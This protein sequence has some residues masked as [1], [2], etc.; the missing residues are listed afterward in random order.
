MAQGPDPNRHP[1]TDRELS[2][3]EQRRGGGTGSPRTTRL[4]LSSWLITLLAVALLI[5]FLALMR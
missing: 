1:G 2:G 3:R 4:G 5:G